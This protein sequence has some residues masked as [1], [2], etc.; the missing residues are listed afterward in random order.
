MESN[1]IANT[2]SHNACN[3][4]D[5]VCSLAERIDKNWHVS[6]NKY[7]EQLSAMKF[8]QGIAIIRA[9][10][11]RKI[12]LEL[13]FND[14][15]K[16]TETKRVIVKKS[17]YISRPHTIVYDTDGSLLGFEIYYED[18]IAECFSATEEQKKSHAEL[19]A[20]RNKSIDITTIF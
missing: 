15:K 17:E 20:K 10:K 11:E 7:K 9:E 19:K 2:P 16:F 3:Y 6:N 14:G 5:G 8:L 12:N 18:A 13:S 1:L 4:E